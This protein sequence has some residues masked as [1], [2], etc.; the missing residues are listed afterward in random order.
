MESGKLID[1]I[2]FED[3]IQ[4]CK[5]IIEKYYEELASEPDKIDVIKDAFLLLKDVMNYL[6]GSHNTK[7]GSQVSPVTFDIGSGQSIVKVT[8]ENNTSISKNKTF[9]IEISEYSSVKDLKKQILDVFSVFSSSDIFLMSKGRIIYELDKSLREVGIGAGQKIL[10]FQNEDF[11][12]DAE[13][14]MITQKNNKIIQIQEILP[15]VTSELASFALTKNGDDVPLTIANL[16]DGSETFLMEEFKVIDKRKKELLKGGDKEQKHDKQVR[17]LIEQLSRDENLYDLIFKLMKLNNQELNDILWSVLVTLP[18]SDK[19]KQQIL[20]KAENIE[21]Y[22]TSNI[23]QESFDLRD[24]EDV[25]TWKFDSEKLVSEPLSNK[26]CYQLYVL[27]QIVKEQRTA[28]VI[29][30]LLF[31]GN[32]FTIT[33]IFSNQNISQIIKEFNENQPQ[34][35]KK[36]KSVFRFV[37]SLLVMMKSLAK[38]FL[39][40]VQLKI[41]IL[42]SESIASRLIKELETENEVIQNELEDPTM[43]SEALIENYGEIFIQIINSNN[44]VSNLRDLLI[45]MVTHSSKFSI[46]NDEMYFALIENAFEF[47]VDVQGHSS[48]ETQNLVLDYSSILQNDGN[49][50]KSELLKNILYYYAVLLNLELPVCKKISS[51]LAGDISLNRRSLGTLTLMIEYYYRKLRRPSTLVSLLE[52][53]A[54][55]CLLLVSDL[56]IKVLDC[57]PDTPI[58]NETVQY[59][60]EM[61]VCMKACVRILDAIYYKI[62]EDLDLLRFFELF[63]EGNFYKILGQSGGT[64]WNLSVEADSKFKQ[65]LCEMMSVYC[66]RSIPLTLKLINQLKQFYLD[67]DFKASQLSYVDVRKRDSFIGIKNL[68]STCYANSLLQQLF[69][70]H[71]IR[72]F[73]CELPISVNNETPSVLR[74]LKKLFG[75][76]SIS[77]MSQADLTCFTKVFTGFEGMP[78]NVKVQQDV[79][80][81]YNLLLD[82]IDSELKASG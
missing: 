80:E 31:E 22:D 35:V 64:A 49:L 3:V 74:E 19:A 18:L 75:Q 30:W 73:I 50:Y 79:N 81:F 71:Q 82:S 69:H 48:E 46:D 72:K 11:E 45:S 17:V 55:N 28:K 34:S 42:D 54:K 37:G 40:P 7:P 2:A 6:G 25:V 36:I 62:E 5:E 24:D 59:C 58:T 76:L 41:K 13:T 1:K 61:L 39:K 68:G 29:E 60:N 70:N 63:V 52:T 4:P 57:S 27:C 26:A 10:L 12:R 67:S 43:P 9:D 16:S 53:N 78:I 44:F 20:S 15:H 51:S 32:L 38:I 14:E 65:G 66:S 8:V 47:L 21:D 33:N 23:L 56:F 77:R